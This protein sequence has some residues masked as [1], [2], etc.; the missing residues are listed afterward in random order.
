MNLNSENSM[1]IVSSLFGQKKTFRLIPVTHDCIFSEGIYDVDT[2]ALVLFSRATKEQFHMVQ[3][4]DDNGFPMLLKNNLKHSDGTQFR[5]ERRTLDTYGEYYILEKSEIELFI[6]T[7]VFNK[8]Y[9]Y[10]QYLYPQTVTTVQET[11]S[12]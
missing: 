1:M 11:P 12:V 4:M 5:K 10:K 6:E 2:P 3:K 7:F 8:E 9:D